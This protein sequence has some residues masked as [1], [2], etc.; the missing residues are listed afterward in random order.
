MEDEP[1]LS[2]VTSAVGEA[3]QATTEPSFVRDVRMSQ[4]LVARFTPD[5]DLFSRL[6]ELMVERE[7]DR[8]IVLSGIG[9]FHNVTMRDLKFGIQ[10]PVDLGKT[11]EII[12]EGPF[13]LL[14]LE[15]SVV[16]MDGE[17]TVHLHAVLGL[18]D[19]GVTGGHLFE[20]TVFTTLEL[21]VA[22]LTGT[23][24]HKQRSAITGL[25]EYRVDPEPT[26]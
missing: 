21:F 2:D 6:K 13:E 8:L 26:A 7:L 22:G 23:D 19:G 14:S 16:P 24:L 10:K 17:P 25:T 11:N 1:G 4:L 9:S 5:Q 12:Q 18:P 3:T 15:G 20:A